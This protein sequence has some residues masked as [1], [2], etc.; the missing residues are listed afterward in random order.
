M[1]NALALSELRQGIW[2]ILPEALKAMTETRAHGDAGLRIGLA[3]PR[4]PLSAGGVAVIPI[5]GPISHRE[6]LWSMIFA[7]T[8]T[9]KFS[10]S[11]RQALNDPS[12]GAIIFD[13]DSP[14]GTVD[15]VEELSSEIY[16]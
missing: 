14:G 7:G 3:G 6:T 4:S 9:Q 15:G 5:M 13:V 16:Q 11:L 8:S 12:V 10:V 1:I 2:A